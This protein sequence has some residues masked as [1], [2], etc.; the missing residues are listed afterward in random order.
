MGR[1]N[2]PSTLMS[3]LAGLEDVLMGLLFPRLSPWA[4]IFR[5]LRGLADEFLTQ[6]IR[7][8]VSI[9]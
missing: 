2:P 7:Q 8:W 1:T 4:T 6:D 5:P 9:S 3:P